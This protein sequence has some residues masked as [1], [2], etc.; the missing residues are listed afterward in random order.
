MPD[1]GATYLL[2]RMIGRA[3]AMEMML[4]G[5]KI[6]GRQALEWGMINRCVPDAEL[7]PTAMQLAQKLAEGPKSLT[8]IRQLAWQSLDSTWGEQLHNE[9]VL[10]RDASRTADCIEGVMAFLQKRPAQFKGQ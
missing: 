4:L 7:M 5:E 2:P 6:S 3:R 9:R 8:F 10:Q 1:G